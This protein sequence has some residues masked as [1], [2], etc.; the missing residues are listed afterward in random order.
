MIWLV[1][2]LNN[3]YF[4][5][6]YLNKTKSAYGNPNVDVIEPKLACQRQERSF[7]D[8]VFWNSK[9][10]NSK[11]AWFHRRIKFNDIYSRLFRI[12]YLKLKEIFSNSYF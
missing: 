3:Y 2:I 10:N 4:F 7:T 11:Y 1:L 8:E 12:F 5:S 6:F 9:A